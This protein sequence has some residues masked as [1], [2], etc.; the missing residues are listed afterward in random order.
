MKRVFKNKR[1]SKVPS[2]SI[3]VGQGLLGCVLVATAALSASAAPLRL[4]DVLT[5]SGKHFPKIIGGQQGVLSAEGGI[6]SAQGAFDAKWKTETKGY[7]DGYYTGRRFE[8]GLEKALPVYGIQL[9]GGYRRSDGTYPSYDG[10][11]A[12]ASSGEV[13]LGIVLPLLRD[14]LIDDP[15]A[16]V[17]G[18]VFEKLGADAK[19][20]QNLIDVGVDATQAYWM[21]VA[22]GRQREV[23]RALVA[24]AELRNDQLATQ[25]KAGDRPEF[26]L[27]DNSRSVLKRKS[28]LIKAEQVLAKAAFEL[29]L[30][31]RDDTGAPLVPAEN[32]LASRLPEPASLRGIDL[33]TLVKEALVARPE[34]QA[35][36][37]KKDK[38]ALDKEL[39]E[40][41]LRP[42]LDVSLDGKHGHGTGD[43]SLTQPEIKVGLKV[44][45]P[46]ELNKPR[47]MIQQSQAQMNALDADYRLQHD[48][49]IVEIQKYFNGVQL[50]AK[51]VDVARQELKAARAIEEGERTRFA[52]GDSNLLFVALREQAAA[53][54]ALGEIDALLQAQV[55]HAELEGALG[56]AAVSI[57]KGVG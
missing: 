36:K 5:S 46:L 53:E 7:A 2:G 19:L 31:Y 52:H 28:E 51:R 25:V 11:L 44:E 13:G 33:D 47:G 27:V 20:K 48:K 56:R 49:I 12:T 39:G 32:Q 17:R 16:K 10:N 35:I 29:S 54:A 1:P 30:F 23:V 6:Q 55:A 57:D 14:R 9:Q 21:W 38:T 15:R 8:S 34:L 26:D 40:N 3:R 45:V 50:A 24:V 37:A 42:R 22:A 41:L 43:K 18:A 4:D